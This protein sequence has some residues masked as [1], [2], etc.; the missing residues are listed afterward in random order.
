MPRTYS[1]DNDPVEFSVSDYTVKLTQPKEPTTG[2]VKEIE[3]TLSR[4]KNEVAVLHR[5][6]NRN[7]WDVGLAAWALSVLAAGGRAII[8]QEPFGEGDDFL[9]PSRPLVLWPFTK[10]N[11]PRWTW[12]S[13]Y[14]QAKHDPAHT[15]EQKIGVLNKQGW[16]AFY[17]KGQLLIKK[18]AY[19]PSAFYTDFGC[20]NETYINGHFIEVETLGPFVRL[21]PGETTEHVEH[22][23]LTKALLDESEESINNVVL[24]LAKTVLLE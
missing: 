24:P 9:L 1:P 4:D 16:T 6:T 18:F 5:L 14:I 17:L 23:L 11:D 19:D 7:L 12:G 8:P 21:A 22:W 15:S 3:I 10:M 13:E 20:N 2:I